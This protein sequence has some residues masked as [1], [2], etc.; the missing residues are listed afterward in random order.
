MKHD[1]EYK[2]KL[3]REIAKMLGI[4]DE[5]CDLDPESRGDV[6]HDDIIAERRIFTSEPGSKVTSILYKPQNPKGP[7]PAIVVTNG[8][9]GS[10]SSLYSLY[11]AQL[12]AKMGIA[13][14]LY[15]TIGEEER[16]I[17]GLK[18]TRAHD[19][20]NADNL[21][22]ES[23]R[24][25]MGKMVF[26]TIRAI[27]FLASKK[28]VDKSKIG[29]AGN[30]LGGALACLVPALDKRLCMAIVSGFGLWEPAEKF[31]KRCIRV[32]G[33]NLKKICD[34][35]SF[36][37]LFIPQCATLFMNGEKDNVMDKDGKYCARI[38][39]YADEME[40]MYKSIGLPA[41]VKAWFD[42]QG[43]HRAYH[44][45]KDALLWINRYLGTPKYTREEIRNLPEITLEEWCAK[46]GL[47]WEP[48]SAELYWQPVHH[49]G[50]VYADA[51][52]KPIEPGLLKCLNE[53]EIGGEEYTLEGWL[54][55]ITKKEED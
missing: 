10:K 46:F 53:E 16:H 26:D 18:G 39:R 6:K 4:P 49:R 20:E 51:G 45:H 11:T 9:G 14:L 5:R 54:N 36:L 21:A 48:Q 40:Q 25:I 43:G 41:A 7:L 29:I 17:K 22:A 35:A 3:R 31:R 2:D 19:D 33:L 12:Y 42:T 15:D 1:E 47:Y 8:H 55:L 13:C 52:I 50:A 23:G 27:D 32:P 38:R 24:L 37:S 30:S 44:N 34:T 28:E